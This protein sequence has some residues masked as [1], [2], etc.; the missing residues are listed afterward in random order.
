MNPFALSPIPLSPRTL[1]VSQGLNSPN[2]DIAQPNADDP[3]IVSIAD[4]NES[5]TALNSILWNINYPLNAWGP[6]W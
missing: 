4:L 5:G 2:Y 1:S 3:M 6:D